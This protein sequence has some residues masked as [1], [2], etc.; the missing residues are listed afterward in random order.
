M[1]NVD[2]R[3]IRVYFHCYP[4]GPPD[5]AA[6]QHGLVCLAEGLE[7]LGVA[8]F[9]S[10]NYWQKS[11]AGDDFLLRHDPRVEPQDCD[12]VVADHAWIVYGGGLPHSLLRPNRG[13]RAVYLDGAD[14]HPTFSWSEQARDLD[15]ILR[16]HY[17]SRLRNPP[18]MKPWAFGLSDRII[19]YTADTASPRQ[20]AIL[21]NFRLRHALRRRVKTIIFD[22]LTDVLP[23]D[24][25][26]DSF[27]TAGFEP[28]DRLFWEQTGRRHYPEYYQ[29]LSSVLSCYCVGGFNLAPVFVDS[30]SL[31][32]AWSKITDVLYV[33]SRMIAQFDSW[34]F[35]E[36]LAAGCTAFHLD[37]NKYGLRLPVMPENW[38]HYVG[39]DLERRRDTIRRIR[40]WVGDLE[41]IGSAGRDW[42]LRNYAP[43]PTARRFLELV[44]S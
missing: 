40:D 35:W 42:A 27:D 32:K 23:Q 38:Q 43:A 25:A 19:R 17:N 13:Y 28:L 37:I 5:R 21:V 29:R 20:R 9:A 34:R 36:S 11:T 26:I 1:S 4:P 2:F 22:P 7:K 14:G 10:Q 44:L 8:S 39:I 16:S 41:A 30:M 31:R 15:V 24:P 3:D 33:N 18:N 12:I 6:Y